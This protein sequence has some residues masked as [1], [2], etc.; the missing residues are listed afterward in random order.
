MY[1]FGERILSV[2]LI[3]ILKQKQPK[4]IIRE[5]EYVLPDLVP[6]VF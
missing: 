4:N 5:S 1:F 6:L 2:N 3:L